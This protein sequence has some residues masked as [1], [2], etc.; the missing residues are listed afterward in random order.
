VL[1]P[2]DLGSVEVNNAGL[3]RLLVGQRFNGHEHHGNWRLIN[4]TRSSS[5]YSLLEPVLRSMEVNETKP[6][7]S[8]VIASVNG[9]PILGECLDSIRRQTQVKD[10]EVVVVNR[11]AKGVGATIKK[12]HPWVKL[13]EASTETSIPHLRAMAFRQCEGDV[14]AVI[15]DHC[16]LEPNW[17][18]R[19]LEAHQTPYAAIGGVVENGACERLV[20]WAH[21]FCE[22]SEL[23]S[24]ISE[25]EA[26]IIPGNNVGYKRWV[27]DQFWP[28]IER[29]VWDSTLHEQIRNAGIPLY[30]L[31]S[32]RVRHKMSASLWWFMSQKFHFARSFSSMR[33]VDA[34]WLRRAAYG[35]GTALLPLILSQRIFGRVWSIRTY[36]RELLLSFPILVL[37]LLSWAV[38]EAAGYIFGPGS[39]HAKVA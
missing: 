14:V 17:A 4:G 24:P 16:I 22:Y 18:G 32:L 27:L 21:F 39:S 15:E 6:R 3:G 33:F 34:N 2:G 38:G 35:A 1:Q 23:M 37:L 30:R 26:E 12:H 13:I 31:P 11:C 9:F 29:G 8:V 19:L 36:R 25:G 10:L 28:L 5:P 7:L 20:D